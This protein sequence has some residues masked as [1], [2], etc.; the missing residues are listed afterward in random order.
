MKRKLTSIFFIWFSF[1]QSIGVLS[2]ISPALFNFYL[3]TWPVT[4]LLLTIDWF[5]LP[6][7]GALEISILL[8]HRL[9]GGRTHPVQITVQAANWHKGKKRFL[10]HFPR[11]LTLHLM[12]QFLRFSIFPQEKQFF[13]VSVIPKRI[14]VE[15][16]S[17]FHLI[18]FSQLG[19]WSQQESVSIDPLEFRVF[20]ETNPISSQ[21]FTELTRNQQLFSLGNRKMLRDKEP[22]QFHSIRPYQFPDPM[23]FIDAKRSAK[24]QHLM[25]RLYDS[26]MAH[27]LTIGLDVGRSL[28]GT[29]QN[30]SK[31]DYY[32]SGCLSLAENAIKNSDKVSFFAFSQQLHHVIRKTSYFK[33]FHT[34]FMDSEALRPRE[35]ESNFQVVLRA[36]RE[37]APQRSLFILLTDFSRPS[38]QEAILSTLGPL[39]QKHLVVLVSLIDQQYDLTSKVLNF[40]G[41]LNLQE[42][43]HYLY[44]YWLDDKIKTFQM[45]CSRLGMG[46]VLVHENDWMSIIPKVYSLMRASV[47]M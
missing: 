43:S 1:F 35:E 39:T 21:A 11:S 37:L 12:P 7:L 6:P 27:H 33:P 4:L 19:L 40:K 16:W 41:E 23:R 17:A 5:S 14:G 31:Y 30:S 13:S 22:A 34:I 26:F 38:V 45:H 36:S 32:V 28:L 46:S 15:K 42:Y 24:Y 20:P 2:L 18:S 10:M 9:I 8:P 29:I 44:N 25:T 3:L 47:R